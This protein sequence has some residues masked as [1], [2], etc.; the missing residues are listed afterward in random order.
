MTE[1]VNDFHNFDPDDHVFNSVFPGACPK[2]SCLF[3]CIANLNKINPL[4]NLSLF[5]YVC[6][7]HANGLAY[8]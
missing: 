4:L 1:R 6:N 7:F 8:E 2:N 3:Y 5:N